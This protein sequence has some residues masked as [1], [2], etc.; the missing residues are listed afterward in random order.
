MTVSPFPAE[1]RYVF[2]TLHKSVLGGP[3][4]PRGKNLIHFFRKL[5]RVVQALHEIGISHEDLKRSN[6]LLSFDDDGMGPALADFGFSQF[7]PRGGKVRSLGGTFDYS[8]PE[9]VAVGTLA[10]LLMTQ[11][12]RYDPCANDV[13]ALGI[14]LVKMLNIR[15]PY[16]SKTDDSKAARKRILTHP[17]LWSWTDADLRSGRA[18]LIMG[19]LDRDPV[20]RSTVSPSSSS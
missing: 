1:T 13:W 11:D 14:L 8:S 17:P 16:I 2:L 7:F 19:M 10:I 5:L 9:K 15:H 20:A 3:Y 6:V 12:E 18:D 4:D